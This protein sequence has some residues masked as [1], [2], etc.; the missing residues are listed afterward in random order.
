M[1]KRQLLKLFV[2]VNNSKLL[3]VINMRLLFQFVLIA[4]NFLGKTES[5]VD[6]VA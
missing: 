1:E 3:F 2:W 4:W 5:D 6:V